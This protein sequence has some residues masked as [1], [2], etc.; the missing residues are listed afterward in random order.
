MSIQERDVVDAIG[1]EAK[2]GK[3]ILTITD[4]LDWSN[5]HAHLLALQEKM[6]TYVRFIESGEL[7]RAYVKA[8]GRTPVIDIVTR[9]EIPKA[10]IQFFDRARSL[11][12]ESGIELRTRVLPD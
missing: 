7:E 9:L 8:A 12:D 5:E 6:N 1:I 10:C 3:V 11:L 2:S 4:H